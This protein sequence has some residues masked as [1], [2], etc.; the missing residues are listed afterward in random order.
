MKYKLL[1]SIL[2]CNVQITKSME[3]NPEAVLLSLINLLNAYK[4][5]TPHFL[6]VEN[7]A[8]VTLSANQEPALEETCTISDECH[9][10]GPIMPKAK[11]RELEKKILKSFDAQSQEEDSW[12]IIPSNK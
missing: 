4:G 7:S 1:I 12:V 6:S 9:D 11:R 5:P 2:L 3:L 8:L 10:T